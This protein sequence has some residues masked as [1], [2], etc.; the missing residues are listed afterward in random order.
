[1]H[2]CPDQN[3][4][5]VIRRKISYRTKGLAS[6]A[7]TSNIYFPHEDDCGCPTR[8]ETKY[9]KNK[10]IATR[11]KPILGSYLRTLCL[12]PCELRMNSFEAFSSNAPQ[13]A[14][15]EE[16]LIGRRIPADRQ[17]QWPRSNTE[18]QHRVVSDFTSEWACLVGCITQL[19]PGGAN[20]CL[21]HV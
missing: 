19:V 7:P 12:C 10:R 15:T 11:R 13:G 3:A 17:G 16:C 4:N 18:S 20:T 14:S 8:A 2:R 9:K 6:D 5:T 21:R 1:M